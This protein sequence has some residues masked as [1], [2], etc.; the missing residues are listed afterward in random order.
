MAHRCTDRTRRSRFLAP[1]RD[2]PEPYL[3]EAL[4]GVPEHLALAVE[5]D[6]TV[7]ALASCRT[8]DDGAEVA[9]LVEDTRQR[10]GIGGGLLD[11]LVAHADRN[12]IRTL[13]ATVAGDQPW[14]ARLLR[15]YGPCR[16]TATCG[17]IDVAVR[18]P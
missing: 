18:R 13:R 11:L 17:V 10:Q 14:V 6:G 1:L 15:R 9:V 7:V 5:V 16:A 3:T 12:G 4:A 8:V 2:F